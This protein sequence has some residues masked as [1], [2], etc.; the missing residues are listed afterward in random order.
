M[1]EKSHID[2][3]RKVIKR[4]SEGTTYIEIHR[5]EKVSIGYISKVFRTLRRNSLSPAQGLTLSDNELLT[6][7]YPVSRKKMGTPDWEQIHRQVLNKE[8]L[9]SLYKEYLH[10]GKGPKYSYG[11]F[12]RL[13]SEWKKQNDLQ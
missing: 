10:S 13:Y 11:G 6:M 7:L 12:C 4:L 3:V 5:S 9:T 1:V 8:T 2:V